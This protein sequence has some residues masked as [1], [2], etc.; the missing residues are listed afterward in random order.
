M[1][2]ELCDTLNKRRK[3]QKK[4]DIRVIIGN[5]PYSSGQKSENDNNANIEYEKLDESISETYAKNS[6]ATST[7]NLMDSY[8]RSIRWASD[9]IKDAGVIGFVSG[10]GFLEKAAMDGMR[11][12]L[13]EEFSSIYTF[14]LRGDVRKN[15]LSKGAAKEGQN[16]FGS[17]SMTGIAITLFVK[18]PKTKERGKIYYHDIGNDLKL[19][20]KLERIVELKSISGISENN[21]WQEITPDVHN[22]WVRQRDESFANHISLGDKKNKSEVVIFENY[23]LGLNSNRDNWVYNFSKKMLSKNMQSTTAFYNSELES[24]ES[25]IIKGFKIDSEKFVSNDEIKI[26]W[27]SSLRADFNR[28]KRVTFSEKKIM[29]AIYRPFT[30]EWLYFD[31]MMNHRVGQMP[32]IFPDASIENRVI[33][34]NGKG[35]RNGITALMSDCLVD[36]NILEAGAQCFPLKLF[37]PKKS[38]TNS[39][40]NQDS[41]QLPKPV[42][43]DEMFDL[44]PPKTADLFDQKTEGNF[45]VKDGITDAGLAH[46]SKNY[47]GEKISKEDVF[48]YIY[49]L[50]HSEDYK[51]RFADNLTKELPRIPC[52]K[53]AADFWH[54]SKAGR[55]LAELHINYEN[56]SPFA[57]NFVGG[58]LAIEMLE[59]ADFRVEKMKFAKVGKETDKTKVIYNSKITIE[60][61]PLEAYSYVVNGKPAIEWVMERQGISTHKESGIVNDTNLWAI[62]TMNNPRYPLDLL[63]RIITVSLETMKI[64]RALPRL[65][66]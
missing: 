32:K 27:S 38:Q 14:N 8:I 57:A 12:C 31:G 19:Q 15:M 44:A 3:R 33:L 40:Q 50:L 34:I 63:L 25:E 51:Q 29:P 65:E 13:A 20:E 54:F 43:Q 61:I 10:N 62:E 46:F 55:E 1:K 16:I 5:P 52:V 37:E 30:K 58:A 60:N 21:L 7:K 35:S 23:S 39:P 11:K 49:G 18:N 26:K 2:F 6:K 41:R 24:F 53:K 64:V 56:V 59:D 36:L 28:K 9:R 17:G 48:Y 45:V 66:I 42:S 47:V 4:L 22:D